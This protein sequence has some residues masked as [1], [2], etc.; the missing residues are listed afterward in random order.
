MR[1]SRDRLLAAAATLVVLLLAGFVVLAML[2]AQTSG[3]QALERLQVEQ[4]EQLARSMDSR[5]EA[6]Y[7]AIQASVNASGPWK[8]VPNDA[9]DLRRLERLRGTNPAART[10]NFLLDRSGVVTNGTLL[11]EPVVGTRYQRPGIEE[12]LEQGRPSTLAIGPGMTTPLPVI[13]ISLPI[14]EGGVVRGAYVLETEVAADS[15][16]NAEVAG[17][18]RGRSG[19]F[20][21]LGRLGTVAAA[22]NPALLGQNFSEDPALFGAPGFHRR[23]GKVTAVALVPQ[24]QWRAVFRQ[25]A[26]EFDGGLTSRVRSALLLLTVATVVGGGALAVGLLRQLAAA[27]REQRRLE[28]IARAREEFVSIVSHELRTPVAGVVGFL[29]TTLDHWD[30]MSED[31]RRRALE[32]AHANARRLHALTR[33][34][35]DTT[36]VESGRLSYT[37]ERIDLREEVWAAVEAARSL[38]SQM[39]FDVAAPDGPVWVRA[40]PERVHQVLVNLLDNAVASSPPDQPIEVRVV[41]AGADVRVDVTDRG[42]GIPED[43]QERV[44]E[45]FVRGRGSL[46]R[47]SGLGLYISRRVVEDHGGRIW[48]ESGSTPGV[49]V[50]FS[51]PLDVESES[52][53]EARPEPVG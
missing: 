38:E 33:D 3:R 19:E 48:I 7:A 36:N 23:D 35:L 46:A 50:S 18:R 39:T 1:R 42:T 20:M 15:A 31:E 2:S 51:L 49:T 45:K 21:F 14:S 12:S 32:R 17:L 30:A 47:G 11:R 25:D 26:A 37:F 43:E 5:F 41:R 40:D 8:L 53:S 22:S 4:V 6:A 29:Q 44:F 16:F 9:D 10:G 52:R 13:T 34:V 24:A 28:D 27:R